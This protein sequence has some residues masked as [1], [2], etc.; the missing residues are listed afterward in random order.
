MRRRTAFAAIAAAAIAT[1]SP[2]VTSAAHAGGTC[3]HEP[4]SDARRKVVLLEGGCFLPTVVRVAVGQK[5]TFMNKSDAVHT[6]SGMGG[7]GASS[8]LVPGQSVALTFRRSGVYPYFCHFHLGM[9]GTVVVGD[10]LG[11]GVTRMDS[12]AG[13][14]SQSDEE[15]AAAAAAAQQP[16]ADPPVAGV[17]VNA[18]AAPLT[19]KAASRSTTRVLVPIGGIAAA[20]LLGAGL[21]FVRRARRPLTTA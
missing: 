1:L 4:A 10:G 7:W 19:T 11:D 3:A 6:V 5:L 15:A 13:G 14:V 20:L 8:D 18:S 17:P 2:F 21:T 12:V 9:V 16:P